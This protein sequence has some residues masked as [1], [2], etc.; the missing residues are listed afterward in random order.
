LLSSHRDGNSAR[1]LEVKVAITGA[2]G[3]L[4]KEVVERCLESGHEVVAITRDAHLPSWRKKKRLQCIALDLTS[5]PDLAPHIMDCDALIHLAAVMSGQDVRTLNQRITDC[6]LEAVDKAGIHRLVLCSSIA[7]LAY[8]AMN[9]MTMIT[10]ESPVNDHDN[11]LGDYALMKRDQENHFRRWC[12]QD[13]SLCILRPGIIYSSPAHLPNA[14]AGIRWLSSNHAGEV[15]VVRLDT[16]A[17]AVVMALNISE[18]NAVIHLVNSDLPRQED[19]LAALRRLR[20]YGR[21]FSLP[22]QY[23][24]IAVAAIG[25]VLARAG[26]FPDSLQRNSIAGRQKPFRFSNQRARERLKWQPVSGLEG[27]YGER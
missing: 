5:G 10:E 22:W 9:P 12:S 18:N 21:S 25:W 19:Y 6:L 16:V 7:I 15:P 4:G 26:R 17:D 20:R 27:I 3:F 11:D 24:T 8:A 23:Y 2:A 1:G 14:H 13:K